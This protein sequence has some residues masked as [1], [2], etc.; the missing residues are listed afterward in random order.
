MKK[1]LLKKNETLEQLSVKYEVP[2][3]MIARANGFFADGV[4]YGMLI[5][6]PP[7]EFCKLC[8]STYTVEEGE[9]LYDISV[10]TNTVMREIM[11]L[12]SIT[13]SDIHAG[14]MIYLPASYDIYTVGCTENLEQISMKT[15]VPI[16]KLRT[17][18]DLE[19]GVYRGMQLK[20][21]RSKN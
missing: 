16:A 13:P 19:G 20:L 1:H 7:R 6:I 15:G 8:G 5:N 3:C 10:K 2:I 18:N 9:S 17:L 4:R 12:N 11:R 14:M 21:P